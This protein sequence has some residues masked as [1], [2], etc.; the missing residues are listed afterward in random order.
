MII[1]PD[2]PGP[3]GPDDVFRATVRKVFDGDGFL[4]SVWH[5]YRQAWV[6]RVPVRFAFID[7]PEMEQ[8]FG[9]GAKDFL[10]GLIAGKELR[11]DPAGFCLNRIAE[12]QKL[13]CLLTGSPEA[14]KVR[15]LP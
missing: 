12:R 5:P 7:A 14:M 4:A 1:V 11:L 13:G 10:A 15:K 9:Q 6:E 8:P 2:D 3:A